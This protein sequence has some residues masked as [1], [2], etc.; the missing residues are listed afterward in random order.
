M[1]RCGRCM[2]LEP[3]QAIAIEYSGY[4]GPFYWFFWGYVGGARAC[5]A[6][7][8][9]EEG[10]RKTQHYSRVKG[11]FDYG[12]ASSARLSASC[13]Y[14]A[15]VRP[16]TFG[17]PPPPSWRRGRLLPTGVVTRRLRPAFLPTF[18]L[19]LLRHAEGR[20]LQRCRRAWRFLSQSLSSDRC[21][22][23]SASK[24]WSRCPVP[25]SDS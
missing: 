25:S 8:S 7:G 16:G 4:A 6:A 23:L 14:S 19:A 22:P 18:P 10:S 20:T 11:R 21:T 24:R 3:I 15:L 1:K 9:A 17:S 5:R 2:P 13:C 12:P